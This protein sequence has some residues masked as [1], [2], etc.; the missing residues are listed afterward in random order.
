MLLLLNT[1]YYNIFLKYVNNLCISVKVLDINIFIGFNH[2][3]LAFFIIFFK[4]FFFIDIIFFCQ[5]IR[6]SFT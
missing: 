3:I 5:A 1:C 2:C 6:E 4:F